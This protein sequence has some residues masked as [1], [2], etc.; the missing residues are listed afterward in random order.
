MKTNADLN[1]SLIEGMGRKT[2]RQRKIQKSDRLVALVFTL[3]FRICDSGH[4]VE[5]LRHD[6][7]AWCSST[8][9]G[10]RV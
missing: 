6:H 4:R 1:R 3:R 9:K 7:I 5:L 2:T 8:I 10:G